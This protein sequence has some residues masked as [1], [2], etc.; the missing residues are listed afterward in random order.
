MFGKESLLP[1]QLGD[2]LCFGHL[3][4]IE[5]TVWQYLPELWVNFAVFA[6]PKDNVGVSP[7]VMP[8]APKSSILLE[9]MI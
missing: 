3:R 6:A 2:G 7:A 5:N 9:E 4:R 1:I 8:D